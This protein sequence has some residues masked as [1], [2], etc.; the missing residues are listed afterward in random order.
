[1]NSIFTIYSIP[2]L[3]KVFHNGEKKMY[4]LFPNSKS[5]KLQL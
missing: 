2:S 5:L 3:I 4:S 1:M